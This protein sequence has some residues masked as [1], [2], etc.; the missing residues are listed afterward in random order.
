M[1]TLAKIIWLTYLFNFIIIIAL[2]CFQKRNP[3]ASL[4]WI[5]CLLFIPIG[6]AVIFLTFGIGI[7][8]YTRRK[9]RMKLELN[10]AHILE[11]QKLYMK[12]IDV[13]NVPYSTLVNYFLNSSFVYTENN[14]AEIFT[15]AKDKYERLFEDIANAKDSI[16]VSYFIIR[17]DTIG[18]R[19]IELLTKKA[20]EGV[21]VR[22][23]YDGFGSILTPRRMFDRLRAV[24]G[25]EVAEFFPVRILSMSK[26]NHRNHRSRKI[27]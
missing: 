1:E 23:M 8:A 10:E 25:S 3:I 9:Y 22:L 5:M 14:S 19:L 12:S 21:K 20:Q 26:I 15:D 27:L 13:S 24:E 11:Q 4:A 7:K 18:N 2:L 17:N 16:N 6:G